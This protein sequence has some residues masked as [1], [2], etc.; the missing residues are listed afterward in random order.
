MI[1]AMRD[2]LEMVW[3][4]VGKTAEDDKAEKLAYFIERIIIRLNK[5]FTEQYYDIDL[6]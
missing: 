5:A 6:R 2:L 4:V 3:K 1:V